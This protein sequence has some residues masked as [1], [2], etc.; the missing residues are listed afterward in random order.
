[1]GYG[2]NLA[3][4]KA[5]QG[6]PEPKWTNHGNKHVAPKKVPWSDLV[7][8]TKSGPAK[9]LPGTEVE[10]LE[11]SAWANGTSVTNG[12]A[13]KVVKFDR[14]IGASGGVETQ[15]MRI[16]MSADTI[17]GHPITEAEYWSLLK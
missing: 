12:K 4:A 2:A 10:S 11:R 3:F 5:T 6:T 17:H 16:E 8:S 13:W 1:M 14:I 15:Y 7:K 9:Y